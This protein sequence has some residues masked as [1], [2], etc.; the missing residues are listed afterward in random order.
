MS[1]ECEHNYE[2]SYSS[3]EME[4]YTCTK[5]G[6]FYIINLNGDDTEDDADDRG[7]AYA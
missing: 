4:I 1:E 6:D 5:C 3:E 2:L 7:I